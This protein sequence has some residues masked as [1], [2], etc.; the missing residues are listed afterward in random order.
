[1]LDNWASALTNPLA[2]R[3]QVF[4]RTHIKSTFTTK[5]SVAHVN[6]IHAN[7]PPTLE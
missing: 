7:L 2:E 1:M 3:S 5:I 4:V 6:Y